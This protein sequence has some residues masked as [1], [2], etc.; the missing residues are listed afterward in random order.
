MEKP[1]AKTILERIK[2][3]IKEHEDM[4]KSMSDQEL[5]DFVYDDYDPDD[6]CAKELLKRGIDKCNCSGALQ[7]FGCPAKH[8]CYWNRNT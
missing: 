7:T 2:A 3:S 8:C 5:Y 4:V 1:N 6:F